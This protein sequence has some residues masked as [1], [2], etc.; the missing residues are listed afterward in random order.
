MA[1]TKAI[2]TDD[3]LLMLCTSVKKV[4]SVATQTQINYSPMVQKIT[5]TC[6]RPDIGCFVLFDGSFSGLVIINFSAPSAMELYRAYMMSMGMPESELATQHTSEEVGNMLGELMNQIVGDFTGNVGSEL[7]VSI[8]QNQPKML[9]INK[10]VVVSIDT[11]LDRAQARRVSFSTANRNVF[12]MELAMDR[13]EFIQ[14]HDFE[15]E[16]IDPDRIVDEAGQRET[17]ASTS[18]QT[19]VDQSLLDE[20]G[21]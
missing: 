11:N 5:R 20:L 3:V 6:L 12:Y 16:E 13:T 18:N 21:L 8:N 1:K 14:L 15:R 17:L 2:S 4:L 9:T 19:L 10:E 7:L